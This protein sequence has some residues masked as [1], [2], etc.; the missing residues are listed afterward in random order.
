MN[1]CVWIVQK[2]VTKVNLAF[3]NG[4]YSLGQWEVIKCQNLHR[5]SVTSGWKLVFTANHF[6]VIKVFMNKSFFTTRCSKS[7]QNVKASFKNNCMNINLFLIRR[8]GS[9]MCVSTYSSEPTHSYS[10]LNWLHNE[11]LQK[12]HRVQQNTKWI[13]KYRTVDKWSIR[14]AVNENTKNL[15]FK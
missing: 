5:H 14:P 8:G 6:M 3:Y 2:S 13:S 11:E 15:I 9:A 4:Y 12:T 1:I 7:R 10:W